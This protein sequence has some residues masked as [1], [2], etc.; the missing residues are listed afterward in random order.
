MIKSSIIKEY[1]KNPSK[2]NHL[3]FDIKYTKKESDYLDNLN[4]NNSVTFDHYGNIDQIR[5]S[6][7]K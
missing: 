2:K 7:I 3:T 6:K 4:I 5:S 1:L